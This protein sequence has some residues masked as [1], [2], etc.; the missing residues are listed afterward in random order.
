M[1]APDQAIGRERERTQMSGLDEG[2]TAGPMEPF[3]KTMNRRVLGASRALRGHAAAVATL[4]A[5]L[6]L[7]VPASAQFSGR[8]SLAS[9]SGA[10]V[11]ANADSWA[12]DVSADGKLVAFASDAD[13]LVPLDTNGDT[14]VFVH[15][16]AARTTKRVS[17]NWQEKE[18]QGDSGC[19]SISAD[20]RFV[21]FASSAWNMPQNGENVG[22]PYQEVYVYDRQGPETIRAS[23]PMHGGLPTD[24][25]GCPQISADG[26]RVVFSSEAQDLVPNDTNL[27]SDIFV[28]DIPSRTLA[29]VSLTETG[30]QSGGFADDPSISADGSVVAFS[31]SATNLTSDPDPGYPLRQ[32]FVRDLVAGTTELVSRALNPFEHPTGESC[33]TQI[34]DDGRTILFRSSASN[35]TAPF[36]GYFGNPSRVFVYD[37]VTHVTEP[38]ESAAGASA[39]CAIPGD[40]LICDRSSTKGATLSADGRSVAFLSGSFDLLPANSPFHHDQIYVLDRLTRRM[41][42]LTVDFTGYPLLSHPCGG[43]SSTLAL[44]ADGSVLA[45]VGGDAEGLGLPDGNGERQRDVVRLEWT[46]DGNG[47]RERSVCPGTPATGCEPALRSQ[48]R[49][50]RNPPL[51]SGRSRF[52]WNWVGPRAGLTTPFVDPAEGEYQLCVY[53]GDTMNTQLDAGIPPGAPWESID[54]GWK[55]AER[56]GPVGRVT[57][58]SGGKRS[59]ITVVSSS[60]A[61]DLPYLPL[62]VPSG[63]TVQLHEATTG[64]CWE[65]EFPASTVRLNDGGSVGSRGSTSGVFHASFY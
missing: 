20:G 13:N 64:R 65:S 42:R 38:V 57:L 16:T 50:R 55:R 25:S 5:V 34:S 19:P 9:V 44:S 15:D 3:T 56:K 24:D 10:G 32:I 52:Q 48:V 37:R 60:R 33:C 21:A 12:V 23:M 29:R 17:V 28:F 36:S 45:F 18:A 40:P 2:R 22:L 4:A 39:D 11:Q 43:S 27:S 35:L 58:R 61:L 26:S 30:H 51:G 41:R 7:V 63:A 59:S 46:C 53:A 14:D 47:C 1:R 49:I 8:P 31:S 54:N 6:S 62:E